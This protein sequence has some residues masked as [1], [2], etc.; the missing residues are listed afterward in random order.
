[1]DE[2]QDGCKGKEQLR[3][4]N[5]RNEFSGYGFLFDKPQVITSSYAVFLC[6]IP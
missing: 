6:L 2:S 3:M 5:V 4:R 1:M